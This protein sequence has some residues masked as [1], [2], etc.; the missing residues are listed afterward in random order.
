ME[1]TATL[2]IEFFLK[3]DWLQSELFLDCN[4]PRVDQN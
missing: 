1:A 2:K 4:S 3:T